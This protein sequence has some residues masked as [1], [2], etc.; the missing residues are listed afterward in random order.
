M[1]AF[2][3]LKWDFRLLSTQPMSELAHPEQK[4][5]QEISYSISR[6]LEHKQ[7]KKRNKEKAKLHFRFKFKTKKKSKIQEI[8]ET[9]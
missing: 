3:T 6:I 2:K 1:H 4:N 7:I 9:I 8:N 5:Q